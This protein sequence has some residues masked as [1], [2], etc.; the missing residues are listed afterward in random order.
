MTM[1]CLSFRRAGGFTLIELLIAMSIFL[2]ILLGI[3]Q[4]FDTNRQTY[5]SGT[6]KVDVQQNAR[7]AL[8]TIAREIRMTGYFP[9]NY[10]TPPASPASPPLTNAIQVGTNAAL[11]IYGNVDGSVDG[12]GNGVSNI[13]LYCLD[14]TATPPVVRREKAAADPATSKGLA[15]AAYTCSSGDVLAENIATLKFT[16]YDANNTLIPVPTTNPKGL[17]G[18]VLGN[19]PAF[20]PATD[21]RPTVRS[22]VITLVATQ[23]VPGPVQQSQSFTLTSSVRL[24][25]LN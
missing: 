5:V 23:S 16:Y 10:P 25:N 4:V 14:T 20:N 19:I 2:L 13:F 3:Y 6:R 1:R 9:E 21:V 22:I 18:Q 17:D 12:A 8:D 24:R 7:V 15:I 11:A